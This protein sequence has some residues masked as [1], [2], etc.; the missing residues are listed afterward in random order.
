[1]QGMYFAFD[2]RDTGTADERRQFRAS[3]SNLPTRLRRNHRNAKGVR[4][5]IALTLGTTSTDIRVRDSL[6]H[7]EW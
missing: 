6:G 4:S 3:E 7:R 5:C 1:M 2:R